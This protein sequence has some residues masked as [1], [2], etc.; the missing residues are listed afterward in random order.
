MQKLTNSNHFNEAK[1]IILVTGA[2]GMLGQALMDTFP[3]DAQILWICNSRKIMRS[4]LPSSWKIVSVDLCQKQQVFELLDN[5]NI[6][7]IIHCAS[8]TDVKKCENNFDFALKNNLYSTENLIEFIHSKNLNP[9]FVY[10][11]SDAVYSD[12]SQNV[13]KKETLIPRPASLYGLTKLWSEQLIEKSLQNY[14]IL[15]TT[16]VGLAKG[17]FV[18]WVI[19]S[20]KNKQLINLYENV[21]FSPVS[22]YNL[23]NFIVTNIQSPIS[24]LYNYSSRNFCSKAHFAISLLKE[25]KIDADYK[26]MSLEKDSFRSLNMTMCSEKLCSDFKILTPLIEETIQELAKNLNCK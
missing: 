3:H 19:N 14:L 16:I 24:G 17:Q 2:S 22:V 23:A 20:A 12:M 6:S 18:D 9:K 25:I 21:F 11:S 13:E 15:R 7:T 10:I 1:E 4:N 5:L 8:T 26:L